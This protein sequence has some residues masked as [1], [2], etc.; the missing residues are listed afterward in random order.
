[1]RV[2][3]LETVA[4]GIISDNPNMM[5]PHYIM[6]SYAYYVQDDPIYSDA[7]YDQLAKTILEVWDSINHP[8]KEYLN[9]D[10][11]RAGSYLGEYPAIIEG[12]LNELREIHS[13]NRSRKRK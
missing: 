4:A 9:K 13:R 2:E 8:H 7:F 11:L 1:M 3:E 10:A 12:A 5:I 6:A